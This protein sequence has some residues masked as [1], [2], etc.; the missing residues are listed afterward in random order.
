[1]TTTTTYQPDNSQVVDQS[2]PPDDDTVAIHRRTIDKI[3]IGFGVVAALAFLVA[4]SLLLWGNRFA[5]DYVGDELSSQNISF[6]AAAALEDQ[7]RSDLV[8]YADQSVNTGKEAEAY[9]SFINGHLEG[10]ADGATYADLGTPEREAVAAVTAAVD[11]GE[12]QAAI[13]ELQADA[14]AVTAQRDSLFRGET[15]RGL[16]LSAY[17]WSTVG[18]IAG[19][20]AIGAFLAAA[21]MSVLV[22]LGIVHLRRHTATA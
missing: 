22:V 1:M 5:S 12:S 2:A 21:V 18:M 16:L 9:A 15:L 4:G 10:I 20:A 17:A 8:K 6:P 7:G 19:I 3:L 11:A 13:D 14:D